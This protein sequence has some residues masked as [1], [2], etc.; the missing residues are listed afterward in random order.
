MKQEHEELMGLI[1]R[2]LRENPAQRFGHALFNL[3]I[4]EFADGSAPEKEKYQLRDIYAD[5][6]AAILARV[7]AQLDR[8]DGNEPG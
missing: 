5:S 7:R 3:G 2:F 4:N 6:D 8:L 1:S